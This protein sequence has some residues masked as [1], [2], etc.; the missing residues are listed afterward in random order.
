VLFAGAFAYFAS[1]LQRSSMGSATLVAADRFH[2][3]AATLSTL[4]VSQLAVYAAMQIPV[5]M[6]LERFGPKRLLIFGASFT[7]VGN[8]VV[9]FSGVFFFAVAGRMAVGFGDAF[10]FVSMIKLLNNWVIG[11]RATRLTQVLSNVGQLGQIASAF[12]FAF[13]LQTEG[14]TTAFLAATS[15]SLVAIALV[16]YLVTDSPNPH[17]QHKPVK[18]RL[19]AQLRENLADPVTRKA[20]WAHFSLQSSGSVFILFWGVPFLERGEGLTRNQASWLLT[21]FVCIGFVV[22]PILANFCAKHP[23]R[24]FLIVLLIW[25]LIVGAWL[26]VI[27]T[28]G[29][30]PLWQLVM[31]VLAMGTGGPASMVAFDYSR[32]GIPLRRLGSS[33][34]IINSGGFVATFSMLFLIGLALDTIKGLSATSDQ[35]SLAAFKLAFCVQFVV[36]SFGLTMF[37]IERK[38][39]QRRAAI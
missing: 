34:G 5:G 4:G 10:I 12:P 19:L 30:N 37:F 1:V 22:G 29:V 27:L 21:A 33:N 3:G 26:M 18:V 15:F 14:W 7:A 38:R 31:L 25:S 36:L 6:L 9:A 2:I 17:S 23:E 35:Y 24:R 28:P 20:F 39:T 32:V 16:A 11:P 13:L 8:L